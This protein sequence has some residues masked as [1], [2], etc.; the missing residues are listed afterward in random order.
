MKIGSVIDLYAKRYH[1]CSTDDFT[2]DYLESEGITMK[3]KEVRFMKI[4][5]HNYWES[6]GNL[7]GATLGGNLRGATFGGQPPEQFWVKSK[8]TFLVTSVIQTKL[9][10][11]RIFFEIL[12]FACRSVPRKSFGV[13]QKTACYKII[14]ESPERCSTIFK[15]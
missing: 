7:R 12:A 10:Y 13:K 11:L 5:N 15:K 8:C 2:R 1:I 3:D 6:L 9:T 14:R 4:I